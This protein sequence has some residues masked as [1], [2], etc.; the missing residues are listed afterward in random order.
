MGIPFL[1]GRDFSYGDNAGSPKVAIISERTARDYFSGANPLGQELGF[2]DETFKDRLLV[3]G[4]VKDIRTSLREEQ[5][6]HSPRGVYI[7]FAQA[8]EQMRG[9]AVLEVRTPGDANDVIELVRR[10]IQAVDN[11][12]PLTDLQTHRDFTDELLQNDRSLAALTGAFA[13]LALAL[14]AIGLYG[15]IAYGIARRTRETGIRMALG[16]SRE[17]VLKQLMH[18]AAIL[19]GIGLLLGYAGSFIAIRAISSQLYGVSPSDPWTFVAVTSLISAVAM[20][21]AYIPA[22]RAMAIDPVLALRQE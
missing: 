2:L 11:G 20:L 21:A 16:A 22:R 3:V 4:V 8:P 12:L 13:A 17:A 7:P 10:Q 6:H 9:Q 5:S 1:L 19:V 18:E 15:S 14:T